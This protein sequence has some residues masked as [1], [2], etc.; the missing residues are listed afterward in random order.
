MVKSISTSGGHPVIYAPLS[1]IILVSALKDLLEDLKRGKD[2]KKENNSKTHK[3]TAQG[4]KP[5]KWRDLRV[6]DVIKIY[7]GEFI[8]ADT[9]LLKT[10]EENGKKEAF[11]S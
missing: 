9:L 4:F 10:S 2:D 6:G 8:P 1:V 11:L 3:L 7:D 5:C